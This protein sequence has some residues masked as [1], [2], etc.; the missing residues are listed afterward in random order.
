[1]KVVGI[2]EVNYVSKKTGQPVSGVE[3]HGVYP[4]SR[5]KYGMLTDVQFLSSFIIEQSG[6]IL[7]AEGDEINFSY[8][9]F[10]KVESYKVS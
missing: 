8:N 10:G 9:K 4:S 2:R 1:M 7:P 6:G 5:A 3:V